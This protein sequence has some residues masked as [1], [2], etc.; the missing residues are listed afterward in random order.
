MALHRLLPARLRRRALLVP[1]LLFGG[2]GIAVAVGVGGSAAVHYSETTA[3]CSSC[4]AVQP[5][6]RAHA[7]S[8]HKDV[9]CAECHVAPGIAGFLRAKTKG[10][11]ELADQLTDHYPRPIPVPDLADHPPVKDTCLRCHSLNTLTQ[12]NSK[13]WLVMRTSFDSDRSNTPEKISVAL[14]PDH[15]SPDGSVSGRGRIGGPHGHVASR[16]SYHSPDEQAQTIDLVDVTLPDGSTRQYVSRSKAQAP[17]LRTELSRLRRDD[18]AR[19]MDCIDCHNRVGHPLARPDRVV[20]ELLSSGRIDPSLPYIKRDA[21]A[22]LRATYSSPA[23]VTA[24]ID[25]LG[26]RL[27]TDYPLLLKDKGPLVDQAVDQLK[28][29]YRLVGA[30]EMRVQATTYPDNF[31]HQSAPGCFRC[32]DGDHVRV[33]DGRVTAETIPATCATCHAFPQL[34]DS[35][36]NYLPDG[37]P[38]N[39]RPATW[40]LTHRQLAP[41]T[42]PTGS[43]C[44]SCHTRSFCVSCHSTG[45]VK[46]RHTD[47]VRTHPPQVAALGPGACAACH[48]PTFCV[49]CH[50]GATQARSR[51]RGGAP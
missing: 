43:S 36:S 26:Q 10:T 13:V 8:V 19:V 25:D 39:H 29:A 50:S 3:F 42:D 9:S 18:H 28:A 49:N 51:Q 44:G 17:D 24:A 23:A 40:A 1:A 22:L 21:V 46:V 14:R 15:L 31:G 12:G 2:V 27:R 35:V 32:H 11:L 33:V 41:G 4:H 37:R 6:V 5:E 45:A 30:P 20:D 48:R 34:G 38:T 7:A 47:M 16:V